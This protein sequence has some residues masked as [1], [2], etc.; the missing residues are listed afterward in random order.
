MRMWTIS[1]IMLGFALGGFFDG[2]LLHQILQWHHLLSLVSGM[3][4]LRT[5]ILWDGYFHGLMYILAILALWGL[6]LGRPVTPVGRRYLLGLLLAGFG[7]WH[8]VDA[9]LSHWVLG[10]HRIRLDSPNPLIWDLLW[11]AA[12]GLLPIML[13]RRIWQRQRPRTAGGF[14]AGRTLA[15]LA[16]TSAA[17]AFWSL[18]PPPG[19][20]LTTVVFARGVRAATII[21]TLSR[22]GARLAWSD[23]RMSVIVVEVPPGRAWNFYRS[24]AILVT[25]VGLPGGCFNWS[26]A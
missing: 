16:I 3:A 23:A 22:S 8:I 17:A 21:D 2:I 13:A 12:F 24:G 7:A 5:Q 10:I 19:Q 1:G 20:R 4:D 9:V 11:L 14:A 15:I 6:W 18:Q 25:G 26:R